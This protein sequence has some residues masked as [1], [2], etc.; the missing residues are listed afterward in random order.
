MFSAKNSHH[1][2]PDK[3]TNFCTRKTMRARNHNT[4]NSM[5]KSNDNT[6]NTRHSLIGCLQGLLI[7]I[8][9]K[10]GLQI[11]STILCAFSSFPSQA[12][13]TSTR[14]PRSYKFRNPLAMLSAKLFQHRANSSIL[15]SYRNITHCVILSPNQSQRRLVTKLKTGKTNGHT[16][17]TAGWRRLKTDGAGCNTQHA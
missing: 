3:I 11:A 14:S 1:H 4:S 8:S 9:W 17:S 15:R 5:R 10:Y 6:S 2:V 13:V 7:N 12:M 16:T